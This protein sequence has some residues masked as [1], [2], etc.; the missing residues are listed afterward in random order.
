[1]TFSKRAL[2]PFDKTR[3]GWFTTFFWG[4]G[5]LYLLNALTK[6]ALL[7]P[8]MA[9]QNRIGMSLLVTSITFF[10]AHISAAI[11]ILPAFWRRARNIGLHPFLILL[12]MPEVWLFGAWL[13]TQM[14]GYS[15]N[16]PTQILLYFA[17]LGGIVT[18]LCAVLP[19]GTLQRRNQPPNSKDSPK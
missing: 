19:T 10:G 7:T 1:M 3:G 14:I 15:Y 5:A 16:A 13:T 2:F 11:F 4:A 17:S 9:F 12:L 8:D 6:S 18:L